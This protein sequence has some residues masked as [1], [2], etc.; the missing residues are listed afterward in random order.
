MRSGR[1]GGW[2]L[3]T[4]TRVAR[5]TGNIEWNGELS[6]GAQEVRGVEGVTWWCGEAIKV[7]G[8]GLFRSFPFSCPSF[9][10]GCI[11][12]FH[13]LFEASLAFPDQILHVVPVYLQHEQATLIGQHKQA[14]AGDGGGGRGD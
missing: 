8:G 4:L 1:G 14:T 10:S 12:L 5:H 7:V 11:L 13:A 6:L 9:V 2:L 3:I